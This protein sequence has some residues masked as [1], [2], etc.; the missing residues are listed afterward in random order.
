MSLRITQGMLH[1]QLI[2]NMNNNV[3]KLDQYQ[4]MQSTG[5]KIN[6]PSDDAVGITYA[7]RYRSELSMNEQYQ[8]NLDM[9]KSLVEHTD[10][11]LGQIG[12]V[13]LRIKELTVQGLNGTNDGSPAN[14]IGK[15]L[16]QLYDQ[17]VTLGNDHLNG[18]Y[19]FNGQLTDQKPYPDET[20][21]GDAQADTYL[22][23]YK[24]AAGVT[25]PINVTGEEV[26][27]P[28]TGS[29]NDQGDNL[30]TVIKGLADAFNAN[31]SDTSTARSLL[32][33]LE[34][35]FQKVL[36]VRSD[37]GA[38]AN[39]IGLID[40]RLKDLDLNLN[41]LSGKTEDAD[42]AEVIMNLK[43][44]ENVYQASL[45]TGA[46]VIQPTLVDFLR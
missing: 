15:E 8:K 7:L 40:N 34:Q 11:T 10:T 20:K 43:M 12:D 31:P 42:M 22:I 36:D 4:T 17:M 41:E 35:R 9:A 27:G 29:P 39:R 23:N 2:R 16:S 3:N 26:F 5:R 18:R 24:F 14:A 6:K 28:P 13:L 46:K 45:S 32:D 25:I 38:R 30:F 21:A 33:K 1:S 37:V 44:A 19:I